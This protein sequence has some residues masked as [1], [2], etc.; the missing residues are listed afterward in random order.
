[1]K[2][3]RILLAAFAVFVS[4]RAV[5]EVSQPALLVASSRMG[6]EYARTVL[7]ALPAR[8]GYAGFVLNRPTTV[9]IPELRSPVFAGGPQYADTLFA[10]VRTPSAPAEKA[11]QVLPG[12]YLAFRESDVEL[13]LERFAPRTRV[14]AGM[15]SWEAGALEH[16]VAEGLWHVLDADIDLVLEGSIDTLWGRLI[17]RAESM[18]AQRIQSAPRR[19]SAPMGLQRELRM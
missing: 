11:L 9:R 16:E 10:F 5:A 2:T 13:V 12:L 14:F 7:F 17:G 3:L 8:D 4:A 19:V 15:V 1:M 18:T 6:G